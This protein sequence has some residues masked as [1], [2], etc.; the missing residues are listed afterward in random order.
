[1]APVSVSI[2]SSY[3][4]YQN[5]LVYNELERDIKIR[6]IEVYLSRIEEYSGPGRESGGREF[7][8][9]DHN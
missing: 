9:N 1:M 3:F 5:F 4:S 2:H 8:S 7:I 6:G